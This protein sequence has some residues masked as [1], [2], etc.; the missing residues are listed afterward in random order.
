MSSLYG[1]E[2][3]VNISCTLTSQWEDD[4][5]DDDG[6]SD[7]GGDDDG[8]HHYSDLP[9]VGWLRQ[10]IHE[11]FPCL[12]TIWG[13]LLLCLAIMMKKMISIDAHS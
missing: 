9:T 10:M 7:D 12:I 5:G 3:R 13:I 6:D 11:G 2:F 4:D 8:L 1:L